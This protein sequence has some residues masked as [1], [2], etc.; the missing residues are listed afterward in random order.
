MASTK[1]RRSVWVLTALF[2]FFIFLLLLHQGRGLIAAQ[3]ASPLP[4]PTPAAIRT[5][6]ARCGD[7][8]KYGNNIALIVKTGATELYDKLPTQLLTLL[9]CAQNLVLFS[10]LEQNVGSYHVYDALANMAPE[11]MNN[12]DFDFYRELKAYQSQGRDLR[13]LNDMKDLRVTPQTEGHNA[14]WAL[15]KYKFLYMMDEAWEKEPNRDWYVFIEADTYLV[16]ENLLGWLAK[17]SPDEKIYLGK[18]TPMYEEGPGFYFGHGGSG[19][20]MSKAAMYEYHAAKIASKWDFRVPHLWFGD[21]IVAK[22]L[23]DELNVSITDA[24]PQLNGDSLSTIPWT[25]IWCE[26]VLTLH[27]IRSDEMQSL[28]Q[29]EQRRSSNEVSTQPRAKRLPLREQSH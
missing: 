17:Y 3:S 6:D 19:F 8:I 5:G 28:W 4:P 1:I 22:V 16:W 26:K 7:H 14:A 12:T 27:H 10:E 15:D 25:E 13:A 20:I 11:A 18:A 9:Q 2:S 21:F 29:Y 24:W 23:K